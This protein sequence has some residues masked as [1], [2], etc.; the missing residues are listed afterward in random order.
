MIERSDG[1]G[2]CFPGGIAKRNESPLSSIIRELR[3]ETG[4]VLLEPEELFQFDTDQR[5]PSTTI[6]FRGKA[7]GTLRD[8]WEGTPLWLSLDEIRKRAIFGPHLRIVAY[9]ESQ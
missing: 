8:S 3:E 5:L 4:L 6:V 1:L 9:L 7:A 2:F